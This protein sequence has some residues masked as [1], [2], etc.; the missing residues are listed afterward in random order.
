MRLSV[1]LALMCAI[2]IPSWAQT[3]GEITGQ[4]R[5]QSGAALPA[6]RVTATNIGTNAVRTT[7]S[8]DAGVYSFPSLTPG[9]YNVRV[10]KAGFKAATSSIELQVQQTARHRLRNAG[11]RR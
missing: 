9:T 3:F 11:R 6:A 8:T 10:E 4:V 1:L 7:L 2:T 5:D